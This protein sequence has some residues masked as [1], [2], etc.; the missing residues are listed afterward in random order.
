MKVYDELYSVYKKIDRRI[1][2][3][4][5]SMQGLAVPQKVN[6][7]WWNNDINIGDTLSPV[8]CNYLLEKKGINAERSVKK[9]KHLYALGSVI[10]HKEFDATIWGSGI[11]GLTRI[12]SIVNNSKYIQYD[13]RALRGP[14]SKEIMKSAGY[15]VEGCALGDPGVLMPL[16]YSPSHRNK[17]YKYT[18]I[19]HHEMESVR[20]VK[21]EHFLSVKTKDYKGFISQILESEVVI[22][23]SLHGII[24]AESYG[25][26]AVFL[27]QGKEVE[28][29]M[30][31]YYD[32]YYSTERYN[33]TVAR[34]IEEA[35]TMKP[36][37][38]PELTEMRESLL[39]SF[40]Y[41]LWGE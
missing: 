7:E 37:D 3:N 22:S 23:S 24:L 2:R 17:K 6:I 32:W 31:K 26:P 15:N 20:N 16:I 41:D 40:P 4:K 35:K 11:I 27:M 29:Q 18:V 5:Q 12:P 30:F 38:L 1:N 13:I 34:T 33:V 36:M 21:S 19:V 39:N 25:I 14:L 10:G 8:I 28:N 9:T